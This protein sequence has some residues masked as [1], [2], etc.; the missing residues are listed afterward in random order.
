[1]YKRAEEAIARA[2]N[3]STA[4]QARAAA[5]DKAP[6]KARPRRPNGFGGMEAHRGAR[7]AGKL[8]DG[9]HVVAVHARRARGRARL[10]AQA[11][12]DPN[13]MRQRH[14]ITHAGYVVR[15]ALPSNVQ[16]GSSHTARDG[17]KTAVCAR[18]QCTFWSLADRETSATAE[19]TTGSARSDRPP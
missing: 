18:A 6:S 10:S 8:G 4:G 17:R 12:I 15:R 19:A 16:S 2:L 9:R 14:M 11:R 1:M 3:G 7:L 5:Q 13:S